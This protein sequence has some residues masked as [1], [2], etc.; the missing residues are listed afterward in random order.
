M[1]KYEG[2]VLNRYQLTDKLIASYNATKVKISKT[3]VKIA[4]GDLVYKLPVVLTDDVKLV[5]VQRIPSEVKNEKI[6]T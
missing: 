2:V 6:Q 5:I 4:Y 3:D 1:Y